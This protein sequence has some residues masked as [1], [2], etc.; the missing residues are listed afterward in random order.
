[1]LVHVLNLLVLVYEMKYYTK[2]SLKNI[3]AK[4]VSNLRSFIHIDSGATAEK[5]IYSIS[6]KTG[7]TCSCVT[8][9][10]IFSPLNWNEGTKISVCSFHQKPAL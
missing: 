5:L 4:L 6:L 2:I 8:L 3:Q 10:L 1:M 9:N 7:P